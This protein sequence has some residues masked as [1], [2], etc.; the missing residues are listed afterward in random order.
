MPSIKDCEHHSRQEFDIPY[1]ITGPLQL[2]P[3]DFLG[4]LQNYRFMEALVQFLANWEKNNL[5]SII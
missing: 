5:V 3:T 2:R 1:R 4:S